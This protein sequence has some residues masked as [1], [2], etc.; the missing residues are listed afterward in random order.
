ME[1]FSPELK[2]HLGRVISTEPDQVRVDPIQRPDLVDEPDHAVMLI[3]ISDI[4]LEPGRYR[5]VDSKI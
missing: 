4:G 5:L 3:R 1:T 2:L